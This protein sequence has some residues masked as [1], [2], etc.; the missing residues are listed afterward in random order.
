MRAFGYLEGRD[1]R[2]EERNGEG[3]LPRLQSLAEELIRLKPDVVV[4]GTSV[5][6][7][8][9][10]KATS[11]IPIVGVNL[12]DPVKMGLASSESRPAS[13]VTGTLIRLKGLTGK[14]MEI[15]LELV[16]T[17]T[18]VGV[19]VNPTNPNRLIH[20]GELEAAA[21]KL[22][23]RLIKAGVRSTSNVEA[24]FREFVREGAEVEPI[25][26]LLSGLDPL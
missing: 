16:P 4:A 1:Y 12:T 18:R 2:L 3:N 14:Q 11:S 20:T 9:V 13:N 26:K 7:L 24:A 15:A 21:S 8:A 25:S 5:A 6:A 19:M 22:G 23:V 17:T 10:K